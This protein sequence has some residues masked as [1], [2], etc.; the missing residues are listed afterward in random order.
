MAFQLLKMSFPSLNSSVSWRGGGGIYFSTGFLQ[1]L[2]RKASVS[3]L[4]RQHRQAS[5]KPFRVLYNRLYH[6][7]G[8]SSPELTWSLGSPG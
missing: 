3:F 1:S 8:G 2:F 4:Q 5:G 7:L 6:S